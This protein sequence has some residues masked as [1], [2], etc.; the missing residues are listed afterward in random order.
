MK[1]D[2]SAA[3]KD[4]ANAGKEIVKNVKDTLET[5]TTADVEAKLEEVKKDGEAKMEEAKRGRGEGKKPQES[6]KPADKETKIDDKAKPQKLFINLPGAQYPLANQD[7][8]AE[9]ETQSLQQLLSSVFDGL[10]A[11]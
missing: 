4:L 9:E 8:I 1:K 3:K 6:G 10:F 5:S 11:Q 2:A 7:E